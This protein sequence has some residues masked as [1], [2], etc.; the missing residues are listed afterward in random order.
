MTRFIHGQ[1]A[2]DDAIRIS[3]ALFSGDLKSLSADELRAGFKDVPHVTL[4]KDTTNLVEAIVETGISSS[5]RQARE[6]ISNGAIYING[7]REQDLKYELSD[8]DKIEGEFTIL[9]R[10]KKKYFMVTYE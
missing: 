10:G 6:D 7:E 9:R 3:Q 1:E 2:L 8:E 5:K 4:S